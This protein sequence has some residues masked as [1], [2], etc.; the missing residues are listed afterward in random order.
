[1][2]EIVECE[3]VSTLSVGSTQQ[4]I[5]ESEDLQDKDLKF[6]S[7]TCPCSFRGYK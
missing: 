7:N 4:F 2:I 5:G 1:M 3:N 6:D